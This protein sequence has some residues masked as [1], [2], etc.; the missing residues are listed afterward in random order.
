MNFNICRRPI[1][2][3]ETFKV[4]S[5]PHLS[6]FSR[7]TA[8]WES[9]EQYLLATI[10]PRRISS[11]FYTH[12]LPSSSMRRKYHSKEGQL[13]KVFNNFLK[14]RG[15]RQTPNRVHYKKRS[16]SWT[17][18]GWGQ[19]QY[20]CYEYKAQHFSDFIIVAMLFINTII[21]INFI[22]IIINIVS[23]Q[24]CWCLQILSAPVSHRSVGCWLARRW[25]NY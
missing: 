13:S 4:V 9:S 5:I 8:I 16:T 11:Y 21:F 17:R 24:I 23:I 3:E 20:P 22:D 10:S 14:S 25:E 6:R 18:G 7:Q 15:V 19:N 2:L 1:L 12:S